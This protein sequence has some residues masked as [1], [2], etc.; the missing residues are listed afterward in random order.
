[1]T[2][3]LRVFFLFVGFGFAV[4]GGVSIIAYLNLLTMGQAFHD[5]MEFIIHRVET[6]LFIG[7]ILLMWTSIYFPRFK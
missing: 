4:A 3:I 5:Y 1:M 7:G 2:V 6:Y